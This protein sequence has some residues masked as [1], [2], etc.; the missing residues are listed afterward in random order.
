MAASPIMVMSFAL[1]MSA[2]SGHLRRHSVT[3][4][5]A[6]AAN[7]FFPN[8]L[9][10]EVQSWNVYPA[11]IQYPQGQQQ[12]QL[13]DNWPVL[14][15]SEMSSSCVV[16]SFGI[17]GDFLY[18]DQMASQGCEVH[19]FDPTTDLR[20]KHQ[21]HS[22]PNVHF[23]FLGLTGKNAT[24]QKMDTFYGSVDQSVLKDLSTIMTELNHTHLDVLKIDCE[25]CEWDVFSSFSKEDLA[26][27]VKLL[28]LEIH[29]SSLHRIPALQ[30]Y[31]TLFDII[32]DSFKIF[33][34][35]D[36]QGD[37]PTPIHTSSELMSVGLPDNQCCIEYA[38]FN[39]I[40]FSDG[41]AGASP[42]L[43]HPHDAKSGPASLEQQRIK[44]ASLP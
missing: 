17:G 8:Q 5:D 18:E 2:V 21:S 27:K 7:W 14:P 41:N 10:F 26:T 16:Y 31:L 32:L 12:F 6:D 33:Y 22:V 42:M 13:V 29:F 11:K 37:H 35:H 34:R 9:P 1:C 23:H 39:N 38:F 40:G 20:E 28:N 30:T 25:G 4:L 15:S 19:A 24:T 43:V 3:P 44:V 36:N